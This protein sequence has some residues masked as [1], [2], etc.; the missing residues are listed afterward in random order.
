M[1]IDM[2]KIPMF[3][4]GNTYKTH[5]QKQLK[6]MVTHHQKTWSAAAVTIAMGWSVWPFTGSSLLNNSV[7]VTINKHVKIH[8]NCQ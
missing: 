2:V 6:Y 4:N 3:L 1:K 5:D 8:R 7:V